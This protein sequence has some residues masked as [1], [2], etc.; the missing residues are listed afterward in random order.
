MIINKYFFVLIFTIF[1]LYILYTLSKHLNLLDLPENRKVHNK[2]TPF[3]GGLI[4]FFN[5]FLFNIV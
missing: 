1:I 2:P 3:V 5:Y 4:I